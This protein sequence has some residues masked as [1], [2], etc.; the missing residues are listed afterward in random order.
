MSAGKGDAYRPVNLANYESNFDRI[1]RCQSTADK[2]AQEANES[3]EINSETKG[4]MPAEDNSS[5]VVQNRQ[6]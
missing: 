2:K 4:L 6:M 1:F 3:G 5:Q